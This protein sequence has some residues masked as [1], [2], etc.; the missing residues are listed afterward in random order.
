MACTLVKLESFCHTWRH[1]Q[2]LE[3]RCSRTHALGRDEASERAGGRAEVRL[4]FIKFNL[5]QE[6]SLFFITEDINTSSSHS[7]CD[8]TLH[9]ATHPPCALHR[10]V[11]D[12]CCDWLNIRVWA[13]VAVK[14][15]ATTTVMMMMR[16]KKPGRSVKIKEKIR[17]NQPTIFISSRARTQ[18]T[19]IKGGKECVKLCVVL[20]L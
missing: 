3:P 2:R 10:S 18:L 11:I 12:C 15:E 17:H 6:I 5:I 8:T 4:P 13:M 9:R 14:S 20:A 7:S 1:H 19:W 16:T